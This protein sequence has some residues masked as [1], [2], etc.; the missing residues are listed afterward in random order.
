MPAVPAPFRGLILGAG[1]PTLFMPAGTLYSRNDAAGVY[2]S[3]IGPALPVV[4]Q[5]EHNDGAG[6]PVCPTLG[7]VPV[8]GNMLIAWVGS[9]DGQTLVNGWNLI[10]QESATGGPVLAFRY[11]QSGDTTTPPTPIS[12]SLGQYAME[13]LEIESIASTAGAAIIAS[14]A[15]SDTSTFNTSAI[16]STTADQLMLYFGSGYGWTTDSAY[17]AGLT[18]IEQ[19]SNSPNYGGLTVASLASTGAAQNMGGNQVTREGGSIGANVGLQVI[20]AGQAQSW[21]L[22]GP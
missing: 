5:F 18:G 4:K 11:V 22:I 21:T 20:L 7:T 17:P 15:D 8:V 14:T 12:A 6:V 19:W 3:V 9:G 13:L 2:A 1:V 16:D 10:T